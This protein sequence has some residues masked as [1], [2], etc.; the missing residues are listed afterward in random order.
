MV[1][2]D[3]VVNVLFSFNISKLLV[4]LLGDQI[5]DHEIVC[6]V[7]HFASEHR[8]VGPRCNREVVRAIVHGDLNR[9]LWDDMDRLRQHLYHLDPLQSTHIGAL[10][11]R[12]AILACR[13]PLHAALVDNMIS[14]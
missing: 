14:V 12:S 7:R 10:C 9:N 5:T 6:L 1:W 13:L 3:F 4:D 8:A 11:L 2:I